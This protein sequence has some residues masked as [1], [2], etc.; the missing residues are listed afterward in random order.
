MIY[1]MVKA[2]SNTGFPDGPTTKIGIPRRLVP[3]DFS[4]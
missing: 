3:R 2:L 1:D 4:G